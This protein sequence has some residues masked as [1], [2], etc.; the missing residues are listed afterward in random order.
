MFSAKTTRDFAFHLTDWI[1]DLRPFVHF[2]EN[3]TKYSDDE[4]HKLIIA[5]LA[6]V[7]DHVKEA[8][9]M[10]FDPER[11]GSSSTGGKPK[12]KQNRKAK[13]KP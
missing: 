6:H 2:L 13:R 7:P 12:R 10:L 8:S 4:I 3:P 11:I 9:E 5:F 1:H